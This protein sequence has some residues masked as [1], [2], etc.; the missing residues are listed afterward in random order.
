[1]HKSKLL[2]LLNCLLCLS[3]SYAADNS[4]S[5]YPFYAGITLGYGSTT[6][7]GL[8]P[9]PNKQNMA[10]AISTP[11][12][13]NEGGFVGGLFA[14]YEI[15]PAF[16]IEASYLR[17]PNAKVTFD[18]T[19]LF[20][21]D[22]V[23]EEDLITHTEVLTFMGKIMLFIPCTS[24]RAYSSFGAAEIHRWDELRDHHKVTPTFGLGLNYNF[25]PHV[26]GQFGIDYVAGHGESELDP[27]SSYMPFLYSAFF[28]MAYRF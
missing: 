21:L 2:L 23:G 18:D 20:T 27:C 22:H 11:I 25:T 12:Y 8:V 13:V 15:I 19:S 10:M 1:M 28:Q 17:Y 6:W 9:P 3:T 14:G 4:V 7:G 5:Q 24:I 16:A 26:M